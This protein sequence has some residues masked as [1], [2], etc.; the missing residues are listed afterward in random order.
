VIREII[1]WI[2]AAAVIFAVAYVGCGSVQ[3]AHDRAPR[4]HY[5]AERETVF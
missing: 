2:S 5:I 4:H 3:E 1:G